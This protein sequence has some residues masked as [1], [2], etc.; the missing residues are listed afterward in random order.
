[1]SFRCHF[2]SCFRLFFVF[3]IGLLHCFLYP[4]LDPLAFVPNTFYTHNLC[5]YMPFSKPLVWLHTCFGLNL[6]RGL[7][8]SH[9][10]ASKPWFTQSAVWHNRVIHKHHVL[11][12]NHVLAG[13]VQALF[14]ACRIA[15]SMVAGG[16]RRR[17]SNFMEPIHWFTT[18]IFHCF[19]ISQTFLWAKR[20]LISYRN[21]SICSCSKLPPRGPPA[22]PSTTGVYV[23]VYTCV[24][25]VWMKMG[26]PQFS[27]A[28]NPMMWSPMLGVCFRN[29]Q[30]FW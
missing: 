11:H 1:M 12:K 25:R 17:R 4:I 22:W 10:F 6:N 5:N 8:K 2:H 3:S 16:P 27:N 7:N 28:V 30:H 24:T 29:S 9:V 19:C 15:P 21:W 26:Y 20:P 23:N 18:S 14:A 13:P